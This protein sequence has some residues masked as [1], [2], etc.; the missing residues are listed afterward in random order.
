[1]QAVGATANVRCCAS[2]NVTRGQCAA[3]VS[4][5]TCAE[6]GWAVGNGTANLEGTEL[7]CLH[8]GLCHE[9]PLRLY[10]DS[11]ASRA[12]CYRLNCTVGPYSSKP[13]LGLCSAP[14]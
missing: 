11:C 2:T 6:L 1:M 5:S 3:G 10:S 8:M 14:S 9:A 7:D 12:D 13:R 4:M